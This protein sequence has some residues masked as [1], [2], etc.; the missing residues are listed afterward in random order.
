[1]ASLATSQSPPCSPSCAACELLCSC[2]CGSEGTRYSTSCKGAHAQG[3]CKKAEEN[4]VPKE[5]VSC[6]WSSPSYRDA[7]LQH[8]CK[9]RAVQCLKQQCTQNSGI[10]ENL[11]CGLVLKVLS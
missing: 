11:S 7:Q 2:S 4:N 3:K 10:G 6:A 1:M 5:S 8:K 9:L